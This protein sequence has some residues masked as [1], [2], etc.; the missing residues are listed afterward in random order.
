MLKIKNLINKV[1]NMNKILFIFMILLEQNFNLIQAQKNLLF[2]NTKKIFETNNVKFIKLEKKK[3]LIVQNELKEK[4]QNIVQNNINQEYYFNFFFCQNFENE[5]ELLSIQKN[6]KKNDLNS[7]L[8]IDNEKISHKLFKNK[9]SYIHIKTR[10]FLKKTNMKNNDYYENEKI[11][12]HNITNQFDIEVF[13]KKNNEWKQKTE[14]KN[15]IPIFKGKKEILIK[16]FHHNKNLNNIED[17]LYKN[18]KIE[19]YIEFDII[20]QDNVII[21]KEIEKYK[22]IK[23]I[24]KNNDSFFKKKIKK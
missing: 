7:V 6:N 12:K 9:N 8:Y 5:A 20:N 10:F 17:Q 3:Y 2:N 15:K 1:I 13:F 23:N 24:E 11:I 16:I 14:N 4:N 18:Q 22:I 21:C 19:L